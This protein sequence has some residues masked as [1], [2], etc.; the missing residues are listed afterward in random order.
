[1][2][3]FALLLSKIVAEV[4]AER[5]VDM[6]D[7]ADFSHI[8]RTL[9]EATQV[10]AKGQAD[11]QHAVRFLIDTGATEAASQKPLSLPLG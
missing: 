9:P 8:H 6:V 7:V 5:V 11:Q 1:M 2:N 10:R 3:P 4:V